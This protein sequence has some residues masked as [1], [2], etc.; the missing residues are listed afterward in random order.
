MILLNYIKS[1]FKLNPRDRIVCFLIKE[2]FS[3]NKFNTV[4]EKKLVDKKIRISIFIEE[5]VFSSTSGRDYTLDKMPKLY[6][7]LKHYKY[8]L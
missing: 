4:F 6:T 1:A 3:Q 7:F 5:I 8:I 2:G